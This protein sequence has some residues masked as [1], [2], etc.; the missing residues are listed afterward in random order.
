MAIVIP[1]VAKFI[2]E[3]TKD[4]QKAIVETEKGYNNVAKGVHKLA[5]PS[6]AIVAGMGAALFTMAKN[7]GGSA[8]AQAKLNQS[9]KA[10]GYEDLSDE[11]GAYAEALQHQIGVSD[12]DIKATMQRLSAYDATAS[13]A[14]MMARAT[15]A[16]ANM[17]AAG[18]GT[19]DSAAIA[20]GRA[21]QN[22]EK[23]IVAL[24]KK[25]VQ[26]TKV[27]EDQIKAMM[28]AGDQAGAQALIME[29]VESSYD[30][31]AE[32]SASGTAKMKLAWDEASEAIGETLAPLIG[33]LNALLTKL[34]HFATENAR[35]FRILAVAI[36]GI[37]GIIVVWDAINKVMVTMKAMNKVMHLSALAAK[38]YKLSM[39]LIGPAATGT[40]KGIAAMTKGLHLQAAALKV[41]AVASKVFK[42]A[43][44]MMMGPI[45]WITAAII[46]LAI[47]IIK[48]WDK[49]K[50]VTLKVW[51]WISG[52]L[53]KI[54]SGLKSAVTATWN[55]ITRIISKAWDLIKRILR[56]NPFII[57]LTH[58]DKIKA[59]VG[60]AFDWI[61]SKVSTVWNAIKGLFKVN[62]FTA[63][64]GFL[65]TLKGW[66]SSTFDWITG[67]INDFLAKVNG[68]VDS[69]QGAFNK[70]KDIASKIPRPGKGK[71]APDSAAV[72]FPVTR[73][74]AGGVPAPTTT[75]TRA[76]G[77]GG[78]PTINVYG[79]LDP[80][81]VAR[82]IRH[83]L[84][85]HDQRQGKAVVRAVAF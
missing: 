18:F 60:A 16:A 28:E 20:L 80:E 29:E 26:F 67:K 21:L 71:G 62:P 35:A 66:F 70:A 38:A 15:L 69:V 6:K 84:D 23:G 83:L 12:E 45:G 58:L 33:M 50:A 64:Q 25:G 30:G 17:S 75:A 68:M 59:W 2:D 56:L 49:I 65:N 48:N 27:Q 9:L 41:A 46:A 7:A 5:G 78:G 40:V 22:P 81:G 63:I 54:W 3:G 79:A 39:K 85:K 19:M 74:L 11:A 43:M 14:D 52:Y 72:A 82:Q 36:M 8:K 4:A 77:G 55:F 53:K 57:V 24:G 44:R 13:S 61:K 31:V 51:G 37:A 42:T 76:A 73:M 1:I 10:A 32:A 34:A 47:V